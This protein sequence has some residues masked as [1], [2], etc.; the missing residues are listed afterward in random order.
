MEYKYLYKNLSDAKRSGLDALSEKE[1]NAQIKKLNEE[2]DKTDYKGLLEE[3]KAAVDAAKKND[4]NAFHNFWNKLRWVLINAQTENYI[5]H[6][7]RGGKQNLSKYDSSMLCLSD[8]LAD[9]NE[10]QKQRMPSEKY[11]SFI[12]G[13]QKFEDTANASL[14]K[15]IFWPVFFLLLWI[16]VYRLFSAP[17]MAQVLSWG[18]WQNL[19]YIVLLIIV[20]GVI[21][22]CVTNGTGF[23][24][25][26]VIG[27]VGVAIIAVVAQYAVTWVIS[28]F[29]AIDANFENAGE[30]TA[31]LFFIII[32][33]LCMITIVTLISTFSTH[34]KAIGKGM[35][36]RMQLSSLQKDAKSLEEERNLY[37]LIVETAVLCEAD[38]RW[39][40][41]SQEKAQKIAS[42]REFFKEL[43][44]G[45]DNTKK[46]ADTR[47]N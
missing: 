23:L 35:K 37:G 7:L 38:A 45:Y 33:I 5:V 13:A 15:L 27:I 46:V 22:L 4:S 30:F 34:Y 25:A 32:L 1:R 44:D 47:K 43:C 6:I 16:G 12:A 17:F 2:W 28:L 11:R 18:V 31:L 24:L 26:F 9:L 29:P 36:K 39:E 20:M 3:S 8:V 10:E 40:Q 14:V 21:V 42:V 19:I 41:D